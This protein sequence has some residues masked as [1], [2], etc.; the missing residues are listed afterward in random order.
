M[1]SASPGKQ[2]VEVTAG[3]N[4][5]SVAAMPLPLAMQ[6]LPEDE[7]CR[8]FSRSYLTQRTQLPL[9]KIASQELA[10]R[11]QLNNQHA[12]FCAI[13]QQCSLEDTPE[14]NE[15]HKGPTC[16][17]KARVCTCTHVQRNNCSQIPWK[18]LLLAHCM[19]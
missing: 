8:L 10:A 19:S 5:M 3:Q 14:Q 2:L 11:A 4:K 17:Q 1:A 6:F 18:R 13:V 9:R 16:L 15:C 12:Q 7:T